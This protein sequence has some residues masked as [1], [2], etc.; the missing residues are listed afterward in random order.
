MHIGGR[1]NIYPHTLEL[2]KNIPYMHVWDP[3]KNLYG[4]ACEIG[5]FTQLPEGWFLWY[6]TDFFWTLQYPKMFC[7]ITFQ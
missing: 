2:P 3:G 6:S 4:T 7:A 1:R 5:N